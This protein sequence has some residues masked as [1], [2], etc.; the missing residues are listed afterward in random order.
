[1]HGVCHRKQCFTF[2]KLT[3]A[4][5]YII[6]ILVLGVNNSFKMTLHDKHEFMILTICD[7]VPNLIIFPI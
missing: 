3:Y 7:N 2:L 5:D 6:T 4:I 1:M